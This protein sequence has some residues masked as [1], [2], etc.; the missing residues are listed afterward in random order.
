M[1]ICIRAVFNS[2]VSCGG[3][4][5]LRAFDQFQAEDAVRGLSRKLAKHT[6][7]EHRVLLPPRQR[8]LPDPSARHQ[9]RG[10][11][12][13]EF[14]IT[15][16]EEL[17]HRHAYEIRRIEGA[18]GERVPNCPPAAESV[19]EIAARDNG[20]AEHEHVDIAAGANAFD[21]VPD[22]RADSRRLV[23]DDQDVTPVDSL[24]L[25]SLVRRDALDVIRVRDAQFGRAR[26]WERDSGLSSSQADFIPHQPN[27]T[28]A[29]SGVD[30][31]SLR[32]SY[33]PPQGE[34]G[35]LIRLSARV[36]SFDRD[37]EASSPPRA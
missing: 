21:R 24:E 10:R 19:E 31:L 35:G 20:V 12:V 8:P 32:E 34:P 5:A 15:H 30:D 36:A 16:C 6:G 23:R 2:S 4:I 27:L 11:S 1:P 13:R 29:G 22:V 14:L 7:A 33:Q 3:G 18:Y 17:L 37:Q 26:L 28:P 9:V 25:H